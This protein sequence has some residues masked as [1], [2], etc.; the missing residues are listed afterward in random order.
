MKNNY[1]KIKKENPFPQKKDVISNNPKGSTIQLISNC[2][3]LQ[4]NKFQKF[5]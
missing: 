1:Q 2:F 3:D 4:V 5:Q